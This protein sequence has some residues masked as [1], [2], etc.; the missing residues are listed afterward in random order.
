M[1]WACAVQLG[2]VGE[3]VLANWQP[4]VLYGHSILDQ[5]VSKLAHKYKVNGY[6]IPF[7]PKYAI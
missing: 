6:I 7:S 3:K 4:D 2:F 5:N 1:K